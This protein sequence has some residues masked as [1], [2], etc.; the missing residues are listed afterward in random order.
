MSHLGLIKEGETYT[1]KEGK[2][3]RTFICGKNI[4]LEH[5]YAGENYCQVPGMRDDREKDLYSLSKETVF[6]NTWMVF[7][8]FLKINMW[9]RLNDNFSNLYTLVLMCI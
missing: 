2:Y 4:L 1:V 5:E 9:M 6:L 8:I 7:F 3:S